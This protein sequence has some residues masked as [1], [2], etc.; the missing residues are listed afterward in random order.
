MT[1]PPPHASLPALLA[2]RAFDLA[3]LARGQ[4]PWSPWRGDENG[5]NRV[6]ICELYGTVGSGGSA[7]LLR[8]AKNARVPA[9][10]HTG[11]EQI[12]I[13]AG[14][15]RDE[16]GEYLAGTMVINPPGSRHSVWAPEGCIALVV[17]SSPI[18]F[19]SE[20]S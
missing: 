1:V 9:H 13:L 12:F 20:S 2:E 19:L 15:Q 17:W 16:L 8:Y 6:D 5:D 11:F 18:V 10:E 4:V 7:A 14:S 3:A